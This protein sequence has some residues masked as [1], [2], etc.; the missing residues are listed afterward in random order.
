MKKPRPKDI[1]PWI[2]LW[3]NPKWPTGGG[4]IPKYTYLS[5]FTYGRVTSHRDSPTSH[6]T[7]N[8]HRRKTRPKTNSIINHDHA[9]CQLSMFIQTCSSLLQ[10]KFTYWGL[11]PVT[12]ELLMS[13][14]SHHVAWRWWSFIVLSP[15]VKQCHKEDPF[16][17]PTFVSKFQVLLDKNTVALL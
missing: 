15:I 8:R 5:I 2:L 9:K 14:R 7:H 10:I 17:Y 16:L 6:Q 4:D 11:H 1:N 12:L 3:D 13:N